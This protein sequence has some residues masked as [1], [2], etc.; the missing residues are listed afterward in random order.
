MDNINVFSNSR[1]TWLKKAKQS[2]G[3][4]IKEYVHFLG[5]VTEKFEYLGIGWAD[6]DSKAKFRKVI[7]FY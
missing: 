3:W 2:L 5:V 6:F 1:I 7:K 4:D